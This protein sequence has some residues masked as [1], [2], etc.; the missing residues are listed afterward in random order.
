MSFLENQARA[1]YVISIAAELAG[2][3]PQTLREYERRGLVKPERSDAGGRRY[4]DVD[5][6]RLRRIQ[7]LSNEGLNLEGVRK[8]ME[9]ED[10]V[11]HLKVKVRQLVEERARMERQYRREIVPFPSTGLPIWSGKLPN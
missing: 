2:M 10:E 4:S 6:D 11:E 7:T 1:V 3:H 9:L 5:V 8:V